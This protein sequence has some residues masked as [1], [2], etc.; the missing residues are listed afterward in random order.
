MDNDANVYALAE[1]W[2]G[3]GKGYSNFIAVTVGP[4]IGSGIMLGNTLYTGGNGDAGE[5]GHTVIQ[6]DG[7][8]C[9]CGQRGCLELYASDK[10]VVSEAYRAIVYET[11]PTRLKELNE[12]SAESVCL[13]A[14]EGDECA[15]GILTRR[16]E[17]LGIGLRNLINLFN[18]QAIML[19]GEGLCGSQ[20][21]MEGIR[22]R[23]GESEFRQPFDLHLSQ[24]GEDA[25][26]I[27]ACG[28]VE[29]KV[30]KRSGWR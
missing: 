16:G 3:H 11:H 21:L 8:V 27:G 9:Y 20:Y 5:F 1:K 28:L 14:G 18:P 19:G 4:G 17:Y 6:G 15:R 29:S 30:F 2:V 10:F 26:L 7:A 25:W 23:L 13:L 24:L 22:R 12:V